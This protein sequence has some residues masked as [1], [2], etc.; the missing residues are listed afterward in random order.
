MTE[1]RALGETGGAGGVLNVHRLVEMQAVLPRLELFHRDAGTQIRQ[2]R[3]RQ[4]TG[5][6]LRVEAD[7][8]AQIRQALRLQLTDGVLGQLRRQPLQHRVVIGGLERTGAHQPLTAGLLEHILKFRAAVGRVDVDQNHPDFCAGK[9]A[10]APLRAV[11]RPNAQAVPRLQAQRQ[12]RPG[13]Q[14]DGMRQLRPGVAQLLMTHDQ[15]FAPWVLGDRVVERLANGH[16]QQGF[17][18]R[19]A[20][21][22]VLWV[23]TVLIHDD[24]Y[25][26]FFVGAKPV[27]E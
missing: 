1:G 15:R 9:L 21:V 27:G 22:A 13:V 24:P 25:I 19:T 23:S 18:L 7:H 26:V 10:D 2:L 11:R 14:L 8:A 17:V 3:P 4:E 16:R 5:R 12:H 20:A 6:W